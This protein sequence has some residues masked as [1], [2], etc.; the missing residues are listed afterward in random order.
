MITAKFSEGV[1]PTTKKNLKIN[2]PKEKLTRSSFPHH[3]E[4]IW[5]NLKA[6]QISGKIIHIMT[7]RESVFH[8]LN[9]EQMITF[10]QNLKKRGT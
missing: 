7:N 2:N 9:P 1:V 3:F 6:S 8:W 5:L 10:W 4:W